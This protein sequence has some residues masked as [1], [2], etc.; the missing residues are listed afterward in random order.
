MKFLA[1]CEADAMETKQL[2]QILISKFSSRQPPRPDSEW[3]VMWHDLCTLQEKAFS[4]LNREDLHAEF[5]RG[6]LHAGKFTLAKNY[7]WSTGLLADKAEKLVLDAARDFFYSS[8]SIDSPS[9]SSLETCFLADI[10]GTGSTE[11]VYNFLKHANGMG[12]GAG[13]WVMGHGSWARSLKMSE[14]FMGWTFA[15]LA[16]DVI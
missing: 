12:A 1:N 15:L 14:N 11:K 16:F 6:L 4:S 2:V 9:V 13:R 5:C 3:T 8:P 7:V 10:L